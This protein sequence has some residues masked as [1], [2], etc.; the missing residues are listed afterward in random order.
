MPLCLETY[1]APPQRILWDPTVSAEVD[2]ALAKLRDLVQN[3]QFRVVSGNI[4]QGELLLKPPP[5]PPDT[6]LMRI[7]SQNGDDRIVWSRRVAAEV[8]E[9]HDKFKKLVEKGY[10]A[11]AILSDGSRG[12]ELA[13][14]DPMVEEC[15][16]VPTGKLVPG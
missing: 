14:F 16:L 11:Y 15:L 2:E 13:D 8:R 1:A 7:M 4:R 10:R 5:K 3:Q 9:A 6:G 12:H